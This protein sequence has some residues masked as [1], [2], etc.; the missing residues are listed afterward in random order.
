MKKLEDILEELN[1]AIDNYHNQKLSLPS[2]QSEILRTISC[3]L[4]FLEEHRIAAH[5]KWQQEYFKATGSNA[6]KERWA[7]N[8]VQELYQIRRIM[9]G[10]KIVCDAVRS[11]LSQAKQ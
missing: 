9:T 10:A 8:Q 3:N 2:D 6:A 11:T 1:Q 4:Y 5:Q 7:D